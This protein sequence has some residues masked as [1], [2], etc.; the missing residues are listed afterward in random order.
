LVDDAASGQDSGVPSE[1]C[2]EKLKTIA[3]VRQNDQEI[4]LIKDMFFT[5][6]K[7]YLE[8]VHQPLTELIGTPGNQEQLFEIFR[9][10][11]TIKGMAATM[12]FE[13]ITRLSTVMADVLN[14]LRE[15]RLASN[16]DIIRLI[17][18]CFDTL[19]ALIDETAAGENWNIEIEPF[20][21]KL[22]AVLK[23][24]G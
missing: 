8:S 18:A 19:K 7:G 2:I 22:D 13:K 3:E 24:R 21:G 12:G 23:N 14:E 15:A 9:I 6:T 11:H 5:E 10:A 20:I 1:A 17:T 4:S 16:E